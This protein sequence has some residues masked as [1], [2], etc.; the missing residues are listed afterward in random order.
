MGFDLRRAGG[1]F[2]MNGFHWGKARE[3]GVRYGWK[4]CG[5]ESPPPPEGYE[6][7]GEW[8][9]TYTT[10]DYQS[11]TAA[12]AA[13][14]ADALEAAMEDIPRHDALAH[15]TVQHGQFRGVESGTPV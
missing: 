13:A 8:S 1:E 14:W 12:D 2:R 5:T 7:Y 4:P 10:N 11:V 15:K 6:E 3:L 9:G